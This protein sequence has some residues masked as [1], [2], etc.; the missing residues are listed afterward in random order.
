MKKLLAIAVS[1]AFAVTSFGVLAQDK[2]KDEVKAKAGGGV[3]A[4][5]KSAVTTATDKPKKATGD[6]P[7]PKNIGKRKDEKERMEK[8]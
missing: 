1:A 4:A 3:T 2:K 7:A 6:G 5:D 8:K